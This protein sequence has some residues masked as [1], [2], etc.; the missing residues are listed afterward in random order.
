MNLADYRLSAPHEDGY[1]DVLAVRPCGEQTVQGMLDQL[2]LIPGARIWSDRH[3]LPANCKLD[4]TVDE[5]SIPNPLVTPSGLQLR[6][7]Q[8]EGVVRM[9]RSPKGVVLADDVGLGKTPQVLMHLHLHPELRPFLIIGPLLAAG[10]WVGP[11]ADPEKHFGFKVAMLRTLSPSEEKIEAGV[12]GYFIN[13]E[14]LLPNAP[15]PAAKTKRSFGVAH[16]D[17]V[18]H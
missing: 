17:H 4:L 1:C 8:R 2:V 9:E 12:D 5:A 18:R 6:D 16:V 10:S 14:I 3:Q 13:Y 15:K 7:Y 11:E